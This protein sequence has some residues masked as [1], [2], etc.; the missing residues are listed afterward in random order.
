MLSVKLLLQ[1]VFSYHNFLYKIGD[2]PGGHHADINTDC[3]NK[4]ANR[5]LGIHNFQNYES[6]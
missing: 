5:T 2:T 6:I 1:P 3:P 4:N